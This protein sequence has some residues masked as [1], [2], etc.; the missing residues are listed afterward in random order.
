MRELCQDPLHDMMT[1][2]R[3]KWMALHGQTRAWQALENFVLRKMISP[4]TQL[5]AHISRCWMGRERG[6][7]T[8][9]CRVEATHRN[10]DEASAGVEQQNGNLP[11]CVWYDRMYRARACLVPP[12]SH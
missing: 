2:R 1:V 10:M 11:A 4:F 12:L 6:N 9:L 5:G 7:I 8:C 3:Q